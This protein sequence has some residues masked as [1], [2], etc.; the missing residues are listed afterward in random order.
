VVVLSVATAA[1]LGILR[2]VLIGMVN[3][4]TTLQRSVL[5]ERDSLS[6]EPNTQKQSINS[7]DLKNLSMKKPWRTIP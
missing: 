7:M 6:S 2:L 4:V 3:N 5:Q 1:N